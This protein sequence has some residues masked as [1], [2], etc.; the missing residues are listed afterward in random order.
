[1]SIAIVTNA[2]CHDGLN[3]DA[4]PTSEDV[5]AVTFDGTDANSS[6]VVANI[7]EGCNDDINSTSAA[8][9]PAVISFTDEWSRCLNFQCQYWRFQ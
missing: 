9:V 1:M 5:V 8:L 4:N 3:D 6:L 2:F 7:A